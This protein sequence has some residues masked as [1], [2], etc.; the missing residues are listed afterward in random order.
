MNVL[1]ISV[2]RE[3]SPYPVV[4]IG[5]LCISNVVREAGHNVK[6]LDLCFV[7]KDIKQISECLKGFQADVI[8]ISIRNI[9]NTN[10]Q[11]KRS[12]IPRT[13]LIVDRCREHSNAVIVLGGSGYSVF[14]D[15]LLSTLDADY[16]V[17]GPGESI[18]LSVLKSIENKTQ[19]EKVPGVYYKKDGV[20]HNSERS[21]TTGFHMPSLEDVDLGLYFDQGSLMGIQTKRGCAFK[22]TYCTYPKINGSRFDIMGVDKIVDQLDQYSQEIGYSDFF[23]VDDV[24]NSPSSHTIDLCETIIRKKLDIRWYTFCSP[25]D[26][27][28]KTAKLMKDAGCQGVEFGTDA[29]HLQTLKGHGKSFTPEDILKAGQACKKINLPQCHYL[30]F[31]G[32]GETDE[33]ADATIDLI[34]QISPTMTLFCIGTRV[35]PGTKLEEIALKEGQISKDQDLLK[36][37]FYQSKDFDEERLKGRLKKLTTDSLHWM[38][39]DGKNF[40]EMETLKRYVKN[41]YRGPFWDLMHRQTRRKYT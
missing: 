33:T 25:F 24:L 9:D 1:L 36:P 37:V 18:F 4:P 7:K 26:F 28:E 15:Q 27:D 40:H 32:M 39:M 6:L 23:F 16:G 34:E 19:V 3:K 11:G 22:C 2:N 41:G 35:Y 12:Y 30:I 14:P 31:G 21:L 20:V 17:A 29:G 38:G 13:K 5:V 8:G 10:Q